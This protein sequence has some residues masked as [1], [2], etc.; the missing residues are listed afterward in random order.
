MSCRAQYLGLGSR[1]PGT[2]AATT[3]GKSS[4]ECRERGE[5]TGDCFGECEEDPPLR[6]LVESPDGDNSSLACKDYLLLA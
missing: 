4:P 2:G 6:P 1:Q 3:A 5:S